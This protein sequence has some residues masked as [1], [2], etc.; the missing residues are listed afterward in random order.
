LDGL[1]KTG[2]AL[3]SLKMT[4]DMQRALVQLRIERRNDK[5]MKQILHI[6]EP[7]SALIQLVK[8]IKA[9]TPPLL[10]H[11]SMASTH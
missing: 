1:E 6:T 7:M 9:D 2:D 5:V 10:N 8:Q 11:F 4:M 3:P